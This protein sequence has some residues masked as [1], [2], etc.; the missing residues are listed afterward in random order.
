[1]TLGNMTLI[2]EEELSLC[3][4]KTDTRK[5]RAEFLILSYVRI[6]TIPIMYVWRQNGHRF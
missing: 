6:S 5:E 4:S 2:M 1:V 3:T